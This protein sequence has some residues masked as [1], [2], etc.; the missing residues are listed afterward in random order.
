M[1][2]TDLARDNLNSLARKIDH[3]LDGEA[4]KGVDV[5]PIG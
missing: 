1:K 4:L 3:Q 2:R 5:G